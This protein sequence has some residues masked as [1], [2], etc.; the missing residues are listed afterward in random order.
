M[1]SSNLI[2]AFL[3]LAIAPVFV[4]RWVSAK[5]WKDDELVRRYECSEGRCSADFDGDGIAGEVL[6]EW[7]KDSSIP[8]DHWLIASDGGKELLRLPFWYADNT[9]RSHAAVRNEHGKS[10]LLIFWGAMREPKN[11]TSVYAWS[12]QRMVESIPM[13]ADQEIL[14][15]I[16]ARDDSGGFSNLVAFRL[17]RK[18]ALIGYYFLFVAG[19]LLILIKR[20]KRL[21]TT[22]AEIYKRLEIGQPVVVFYDPQNPKLSCMGY[23]ESHQRVEMAG[24]IFLVLF[25]P[26]GPL[27]VAII[28]MIVLSK[29]TP[30]ISACSGLAGSSLYS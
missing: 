25:V 8:G 22:A 30:R 9:L 27:V 16:A 12:N 26:L 19:A 2:L 11:G 29:S 28:I 15:A 13:A 24:V 7:R 5:D 20:R 4:Y 23:P 18:G 3:L 10:R 14:S 6:I 21:G 17:I 1:R